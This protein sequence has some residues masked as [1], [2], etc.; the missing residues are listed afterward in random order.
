MGDAGS[1]TVETNAA[2][3]HGLAIALEASR[4]I[5]P[6]DVLLGLDRYVRPPPEGASNASHAIVRAALEPALEVVRAAGDGPVLAATLANAACAMGAL[7][8]FVEA[9]KLLAEA[10]E[11]ATDD[12]D[13]F[14]SVSY[15]SVKVSFWAGEVGTTVALLE[16]TLLPEEPR[17]RQE[18]LLLFSMAVVMVG[19]RSA[20]ARGLDLVSRAEAIL[21]H[22]HPPAPSRRER[23]P[24]LSPTA[25]STVTSASSSRANTRR[26]PTLQSPRSRSR[27]AQGYAS[28]SSPTCTTRAS[29]T[30]AWGSGIARA[31]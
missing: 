3:V 1:E 26:R 4:S 10:S 9:K 2:R 15:A 8:D 21:S 30:F 31:R 16:E 5:D 17:A 24:S 7:A 13:R 11:R 25:R 23:I 27:G 22:R 6:R 18:M 14:R 20:L 19:G 28:T 12:P 29:S